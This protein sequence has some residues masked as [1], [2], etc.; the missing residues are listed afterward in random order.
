MLTTGAQTA[1]P[2]QVSLEE[3]SIPGMAGV[4]SFVHAQYNGKWVLIG[5]RTDGLH[6]RQPFASF[7]AAENNTMVHIVDPVAGQVWS[8][9]LSVLP[10]SLYEQ[11]Q[12]TNMEFEQ[13]DS[14]LYII[15]GYGY[16]ATSG[17]H[18][19]YDKLTAVDLPGLMFA[20]INGG[21]ITGSFRQISHPAMAVTGGYLGHLGNRFYLA[22]GQEFIGRYNPMG[23]NHGPG[24][25]QN[26]V[27]AIR[28]FEIMDDGQTLS[29]QNYSEWLDTANLHRRDYNMT[30]QV[31]PDGRKGYTMFSG[32]FQYSGDIPWL[33]TVDFTD[34]GYAV[35]PGFNQYLNQYHT[36]NMPVYDGAGNS[37][38][39][40]FFGGMS[41][42]TLDATGNLIDDI[43]VPFVNTM[44][45]VTRFH[46]GSLQEFKIGE[47]PALLGSGAEFL[48]VDAGFADEYGMIHLDS[49]SNQ[50]THVGYVAGGIESTA[51]NIFF[52][53]TGTQ[54]DAT[55]RVFKVFI[56]KN[57]VGSSELMDGEEFFTSEVYPNPAGSS[58]QLSLTLP[59]RA[60]VEVEMIDTKG[61][62]IR[63]IHSGNIYSSQDFQVELSDLPGGVY[64][65]KIS[66]GEFQET[67]SFVKN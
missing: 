22:G 60:D 46:D 1:T 24:F 41:R 65:F 55:T 34:T 50:K 56:T 30:Y 19:T 62:F 17:N 31:F 26:Y 20:V 35:I 54:S 27:N 9:S 43:N 57:A 42:Y 39:T 5:G 49:L 44:S 6:Q 12:S 32:V 63:K 16:S 38:S 59:H 61:L 18:I 47:M 53:N 21:S 13:I 25:I 37:M 67:L 51:G 4:Q 58:V 2:F 33:N 29:I 7:A 14:V 10:V 40:I 48:A 45:K 28:S 23:P 52:I 36:A 15:G 64:F 11:L 66:S 8:A 3:M